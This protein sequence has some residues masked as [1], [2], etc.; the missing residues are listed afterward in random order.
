MGRSP[1]NLF[2]YRPEEFV[3]GRGEKTRQHLK[4]LWK[5]EQ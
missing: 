2:K 4:S 3:Q 1:V 5:G